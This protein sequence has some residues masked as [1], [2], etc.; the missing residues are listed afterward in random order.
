MVHTHATALA[1]LGIRSMWTS[2]AKMILYKMCDLG[3]FTG[4]KNNAVYSL[5]KLN[6]FY[7][8]ILSS[9]VIV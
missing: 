8:N 1:S 5:S 4:R 7:V 2:Q 6:I 9:F 3:F